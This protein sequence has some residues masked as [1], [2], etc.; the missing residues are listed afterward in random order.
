MSANSNL[1]LV[2]L[3]LHPE[4][5]FAFV[6]FEKYKNNMHYSYE[7]EDFAENRLCKLCVTKRSRVLQ[8][9]NTSMSS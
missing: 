4:W 6:L 8:D 1:I 7:M 9:A 3:G 2:G 5:M